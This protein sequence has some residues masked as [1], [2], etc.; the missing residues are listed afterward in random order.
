MSQ[1]SNKYEN[2]HP[3][4]EAVILLC[5][6]ILEAR[7]ISHL[8]DSAFFTVPLFIY[9]IFIYFLKSLYR[10]VVSVY[11]YKIHKNYCFPNE[12]FEKVI[13]FVKML[14]ELLQIFSS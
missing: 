3:F 11:I 12:Y 13:F 4:K 7:R 2:L 14:A 6:S 10:M 5:Q 1:V 8:H 9:F